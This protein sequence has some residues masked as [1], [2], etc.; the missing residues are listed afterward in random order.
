MK[1]FDFQW[2]WE[3]FTDFEPRNCVFP[4]L[5]WIYLNIYVSKLRLNVRKFI[6]FHFLTEITSSFGVK[7]WNRLIFNGNERFTDFEQRNCVFPCLKWIYLSIYVSKLRLNVRKGIYFHFS[8]WN[9]KFFYCK[10]CEIV[11]FSMEMGDI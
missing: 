2:K 8:H 5:K 11:W 6:Y 9:N 3:I 7:L 4:C 1:T 10:N